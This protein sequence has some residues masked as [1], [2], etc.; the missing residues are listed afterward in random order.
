MAEP[1]QEVRDDWSGWS[2]D[3][4]LQVQ[5]LQQLSWAK[6]GLGIYKGAITST[7][8]HSAKVAKCLKEPPPLKNNCIL[9]ADGASS[10]KFNNTLV[11][12]QSPS[13][14]MLQA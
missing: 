3:F 6:G 9:M 2:S 14:D 12:S 5:E 8:T 4:W 11:A 7:T 1:C 13:I 10:D